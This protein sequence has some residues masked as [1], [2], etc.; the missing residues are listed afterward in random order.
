MTKK[1]P[2]LFIAVALILAAVLLICLLPRTTKTDYTINASGFTA[3]GD[4]A[5]DF[6]I[7]VHATKTETLFGEPRLELSIEP[8]AQQTWLKV[9]EAEGENPVYQMDDMQFMFFSAGDSVLVDRAAQMT[10]YFDENLDRWLFVNN[11]RNVY[12]MG[13]VSGDYSLAEL[14]D[15]FWGMIPGNG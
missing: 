3:E 15:Y 14:T 7:N 13:T 2:I 12:Y 9:I 5:G 6:Q 4:P 10:V 1:K 11:S 8:F